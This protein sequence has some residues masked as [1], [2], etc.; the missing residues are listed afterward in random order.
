MITKCE[1]IAIRRENDEE[2]GLFIY[3]VA[4]L[5][6]EEGTTLVQELHSGGLGEVQGD[7]AYLEVVGVEQRAELVEMLGT[8]GLSDP[9]EVG[10]AFTPDE[11]RLR[12]LLKASGAVTD[13]YSQGE[14]ITDEIAHLDTVREEIKSEKEG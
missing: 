1:S 9:D 3:A 7:E 5:T 12:A 8:L 4:T 10:H 6:F 2:L 11:R 13:N 14:D